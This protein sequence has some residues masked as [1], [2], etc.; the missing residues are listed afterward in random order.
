[1]GGFGSVC[2]FT[3]KIQLGRAKALLSVT[4]AENFQV[5]FLFSWIFYFYYFRFGRVPLDKMVLQEL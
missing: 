5:N 4:N 3:F 1:M 2:I